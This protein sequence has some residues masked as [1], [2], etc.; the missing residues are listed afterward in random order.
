MAVAWS[1][2]APR[3]ALPG[4]G[5]DRQAEGGRAAERAGGGAGG[6]RTFDMAGVAGEV[7]GADCLCWLLSAAMIATAAEGARGE[8][9]LR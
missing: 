2:L 3:A 1:P 7:G 8:E 9:E 5:N 4:R 6:G